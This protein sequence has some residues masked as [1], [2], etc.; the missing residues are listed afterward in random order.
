MQTVPAGNVICSPGPHD[1]HRAGSRSVRFPAYFSD[2]G[3]SNA[4][5][6]ARMRR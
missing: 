1:L 5:G 4:I 2:F 6:L 3:K